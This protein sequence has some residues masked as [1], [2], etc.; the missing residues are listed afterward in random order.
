MT[1]AT[2]PIPD[3]P[4]EIRPLLIGAPVPEVTLQTVDG[5]PFDLAAAVSERPAVLIFY[6]GGW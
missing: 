3:S 6:R 1:Q 5:N 2:D 4:S